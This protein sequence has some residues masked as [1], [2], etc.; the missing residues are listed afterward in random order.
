M[1]RSVLAAQG[2]PSFLTLDRKTRMPFSPSKRPFGWLAPAVATV[3]AALM[4][5]AP[6]AS[7]APTES[8]LY[9]FRDGS[10]GGFPVAGLIADGAGNLYGTAEVGGV[11]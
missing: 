9:D 3:C 1:A 5:A 8:V 6:S 4:M 11:E 7:A 10:D 2:M